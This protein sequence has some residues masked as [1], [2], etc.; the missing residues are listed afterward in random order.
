MKP[1]EEHLWLHVIRATSWLP[2]VFHF[3]WLQNLII[4]FKL[5]FLTFL[6]S[7]S[8]KLGSSVLSG[9]E[10]LLKIAVRPWCWME[11]SVV[12]ANIFYC[13]RCS[14]KNIFCPFHVCLQRRWPQRLPQRTEGPPL[15]MSSLWNQFC[16][17]W[18][19]CNGDGNVLLRDINRLNGRPRADVCINV[20]IVQ[21]SCV[22]LRQTCRAPFLCQCSHVFLCCL[23]IFTFLF[24]DHSGRADIRLSLRGNFNVVS[25]SVCFAPFVAFRFCSC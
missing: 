11:T 18:S 15:D 2:S 7:H 6:T 3:Q 23:V 4:K 21:K 24:F 17:M 10:T 9:M 13:W 5:N 16:L 22:P 12:A 14:Y 1:S 19:R 25:T 20:C 8:L